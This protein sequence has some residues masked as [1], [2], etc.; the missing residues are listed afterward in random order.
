M[1]LHMDQNKKSKRCRGEHLKKGETKIEIIKYILSENDVVP[2]PDLIEHLHKNHGLA[3]EGNIRDH[4]SDLENLSCIGKIPREPGSY[5]KWKI[6][7]LKNLRNIR[8]HYPSIQLN[9]YNKCVNIIFEEQILKGHPFIDLTHARKLRIQLSHLI[10]FID[11]CLKNNFKTLYYN[12]EDIY[13]LGE[14]SDCYE[15]FK[16]YANEYHPVYPKFA[17]MSPEWA[18]K[19]YDSSKMFER[20]SLF[21]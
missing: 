13:K 3:D 21:Y 4:L 2:G 5:H 17:S 12:V 15:I 10:H 8:E 11:K 9:L 20:L 19:C 14:I 1:R 7:E 16:K 6:E 18:Q